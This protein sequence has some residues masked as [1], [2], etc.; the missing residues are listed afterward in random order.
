MVQ[1]TNNH[2]CVLAFY[3]SLIG[4]SLAEGHPAV[5]R[6]HACAVVHAHKTFPV[7]SFVIVSYIVIW[8]EVVSLIDVNVVKPWHYICIEAKWHLN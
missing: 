6:Y 5:M 2:I 8:I 1:M 4:S 7:S 3:N